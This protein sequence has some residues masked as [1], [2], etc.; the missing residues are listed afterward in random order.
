MKS[1]LAC[2]VL[3]AAIQGSIIAPPAMA[4][5][6][7]QQRLAFSTLGDL[8]PYRVIAADTLT[9]VDAG[10]LPAAKARIKDLET[11]WDDAE[12]GMKPKDRVAWSAV[13][14]SIDAALHALRSDAPQQAECAAALKALIAKMDDLSKA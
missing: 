5:P 12:A 8:T 6:G 11:A 1:P 10:K 4:A 13:D 7:A 3:V 9:I 2:A 14:K